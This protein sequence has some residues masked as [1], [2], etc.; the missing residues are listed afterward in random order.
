V[1][2]PLA[3]GSRPSGSQSADGDCRR[4][5]SSCEERCRLH[6]AGNP[7]LLA[8]QDEVGLSSACGARRGGQPRRHRREPGRRYINSTGHARCVERF[9][10]TNESPR[11][12]SPAPN[13]SKKPRCETIPEGSSIGT[14]PPPK[15]A[16]LGGSCSPRPGCI[17]GD[18]G[19]AAARSWRSSCSKRPLC[20]N[21]ALVRLA[22]GDEGGGSDGG[23]GGFGGGDG[24][25]DGGGGSG[26]GEG[27]GG[28]GGGGHDGGHA[29]GGDGRGGDG[30]GGN[31]GGGSK[32][33]GGEGGGGEGGGGAGGGS[34]GGVGGS[35]CAG[36]GTRTGAET[37]AIST[38]N[39]HG[40]RM[41]ALLFSY[42]CT[43]VAQK[44]RS[45]FLA[46]LQNL[47]KE[48]CQKRS[49]RHSPGLGGGGC[50][51]VAT[52]LWR[53]PPQQ[54]TSPSAHNAR[55]W[56]SADRAGTAVHAAPEVATSRYGASNAGAPVPT[57]I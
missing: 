38:A 8:A 51:E 46:F 54:Q 39:Q 3:S 7:V 44:M 56:S 34:G 23:V 18:V 9:E 14:A 15:K 12:C 19:N 30:D 24:G 31:E 10:A 17:H 13:A 47:K 22:G 4:R 50:V 26:G 52:S 57:A 48:M 1:R 35:G 20:P 55:L 37:S 53:P 29:G 21:S 11:S 28:K 32:G 33:G 41:A 45:L 25:G 16:G 6:H 2:L 40:Q 43:G 5:C 36:G 49:H 27:G 42:C